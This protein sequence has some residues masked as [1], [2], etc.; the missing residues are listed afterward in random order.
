MTGYQVLYR[1]F[2]PKTFSDIFGQDAVVAVLKN[3]ILNNNISHAYLFSGSRGTGKTSTA[4]VFAKAVNCRNNTDGSPCGECSSCLSFGQNAVM[5]TIEIDA[6]S[7]R[8]IDEIRDLR[9]KVSFLPSF[10]RYRIFIIDEVHMLTTE[11]FNALLKTLEEPPEH[12][13]FIFAT[14]DASKLPPTIL[15][16]CQRF[17]FSRISSHVIADRMK[18]IMEELG[19]EYEQAAL[20][21]IAEK[22]D[23]ALRDALSF[24][25]K[26]IASRRTEVL[27]AD[28]AAAAVGSAGSSDVTA[29][30]E[31]VIRQSAPEALELLDKAL[32]NGIDA[33]SI[34]SL[35][36]D[37][38]RSI[39][40]YSSTQNPE[41]ILFKSES[42][43]KSYEDNS[44]SIKP[45][46]AAVCVKEL[47]KAKNE[48]KYLPNPR[49]LLEAVL[50]SLSDPAAAAESMNIMMRL[51]RLEKRIEGLKPSGFSAAP[52]IQ[53]EAAA[54]KRQQAEAEVSEKKEQPAAAPKQSTDP[55]L[56]LKIQKE[57]SMSGKIIQNRER[58]MILGD[59]FPQMKLSSFDGV[60]AF[61]YPTGE[62][63]HMMEVFEQ[64]DGAEKL[65]RILS[66][67]METEIR[68]EIT[69]N[70][71]DSSGSDIM[72]AASEIFGGLSEFND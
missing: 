23:G 14:T 60:T 50:L 35:L 48:S 28:D 33:D 9:E 18:G 25:D 64:K 20:Y 44:V 63:V 43:M 4:K 53:D 7:N 11:A 16:R 1:R 47:S 58:N 37:Y 15:S 5:D 49:Y 10:G 30:A 27:T 12:V 42:E 46:F 72:S 31:A 65:A 34:F 45:Q 51:E 61:I 70:D 2:R 39:M 21:L 59:L 69:K 19:I 32:M 36:I 8:G 66:E 24:L 54:E 52:K 38:F 29:V 71:A 68:V 22:S 40:I 13:I 26:A 3:Q 67:R 57:I 41:R 55:Q 6:A 17:D 56:A 62:A